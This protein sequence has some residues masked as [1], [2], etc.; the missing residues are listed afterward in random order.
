MILAGLECLVVVLEELVEPLVGQ[1]VIEKTI[2]HLERHG[3]DMRSN[4][5]G[6]MDVNGMAKRRG[7]DLG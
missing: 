4:L 7:Q 3:A 1:R 6:F 5:G 2:H